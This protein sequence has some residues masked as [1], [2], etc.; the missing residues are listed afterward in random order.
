MYKYGRQYAEQVEFLS[1][2]EGVLERSPT[3]RVNIVSLKGVKGASILYK[4]CVVRLSI[5][6][7]RDYLHLTRRCRQRNIRRGGFRHQDTG[8]CVSLKG[9]IY[10]NIQWLEPLG[11]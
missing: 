3:K 6:W 1:V 8:G 9:R 4:N 2:K 11:I 7:L 5:G 10:V